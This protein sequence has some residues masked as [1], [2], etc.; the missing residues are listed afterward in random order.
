MLPF[1]AVD[2]PEMLSWLNGSQ[3][4]TLCGEN[5]ADLVETNVFGRAELLLLIRPSRKSLSG[6][7]DREWRWRGERREEIQKSHVK[8]ER[9]FREQQRQARQDQAQRSKSH[10]AGVAEQVL[11]VGI[12][13]VGPLVIKAWS[14]VK[15]FRLHC[16]C[17]VSRG[18]GMIWP[19]YIFKIRGSCA[20][21]QL[22]IFLIY[23]ASQKL[24]T[25]QNADK[26][27][28]SLSSTW[29]LVVVF[30]AWSCS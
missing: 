8:M 10:V 25:I 17:D 26:Q 4:K 13:G 28:Q 12:G 27:I 18:K 9:T 19:G 15:Y 24:F 2:R 6:G 7:S 1:A 20:G 29:T 11:A 22:D 30:L 23:P 3:G 5:H 16:K 14:P 21:N